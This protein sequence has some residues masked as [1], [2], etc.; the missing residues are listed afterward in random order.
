MSRTGRIHA[1]RHVKP[2]GRYDRVLTVLRGAGKHGATTLEIIKCAQVCAVN[3]VVSELRAMGYSIDCE[4]AGKSQDGGAVYRYRLVE[5]R[6]GVP[7]PP[8]GELFGEVG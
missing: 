5:A 3:S 8:A 7:P 4:P 2:G 6:P 1:G